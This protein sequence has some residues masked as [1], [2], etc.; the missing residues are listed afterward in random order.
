MRARA[1]HPGG[2]TPRK[3]IDVAWQFPSAVIE[4][5][6]VVVQK[7]RLKQPPKTPC[8]HKQGVGLQRG[9]RPRPGSRRFSADYGAE[10]AAAQ[11]LLLWRNVNENEGQSGTGGG[12][13]GDSLI[14]ILPA[15]LRPGSGSAGAANSARKGERDLPPSQ[16]LPV[17]A[18]HFYLVKGQRGAE[19][20]IGKQVGGASLVG[21]L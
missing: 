2:K 7:A 10:S 17:R 12:S 4:Y 19:G 6:S 9:S 21:G 14:H 5:I 3:K 1:L 11:N 18:I 20:R 8:P 13:G 16:K 15:R